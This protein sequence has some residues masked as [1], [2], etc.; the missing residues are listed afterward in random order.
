[1]SSEGA[2]LGTDWVI[3]VIDTA[4]N[5]VVATTKVDTGPG[6][7]AATA[8]SVYVANLGSSTVSVIDV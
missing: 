3:S 1:M 5:M 8:R 7:V 4:K 6:L 2:P